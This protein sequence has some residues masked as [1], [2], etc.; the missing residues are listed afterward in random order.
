MGSEEYEELQSRIE[1]AESIIA[2]HEEKFRMECLSD[3][4]GLS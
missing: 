3:G 2:I 4:G 1:K